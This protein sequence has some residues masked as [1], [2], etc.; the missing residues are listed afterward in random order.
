MKLR[1]RK[2][3]ELVL[4]AAELKRGVGTQDDVAP[5]PRARGSRPGPRLN[6]SRGGSD[7]IDVYSDGGTDRDGF[8]GGEVAV[9]TAVPTTQTWSR[10]TTPDT[11]AT[12]S[13]GDSPTSVT[14]A[15]PTQYRPH[16]MRRS[17]TG[18]GGRWSAGTT[19]WTA[20]SA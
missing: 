6:G 14:S 11:L 4:R 8:G 5:S 17:R 2:I 1:C 9:S 7:A 12:T 20:R 18:G 13:A 15:T 16:C 10:T 19:R 3:V